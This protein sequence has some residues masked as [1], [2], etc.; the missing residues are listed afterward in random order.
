MTLVV[1]PT[2]WKELKELAKLRDVEVSNV[3]TFTDNG[4]FHVKEFA[5]NL[6]LAQR[7]AVLRVKH[8]MNVEAVRGHV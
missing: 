1:D 2:R 3:G 6:H 5:E 8:I 4:K 7:G